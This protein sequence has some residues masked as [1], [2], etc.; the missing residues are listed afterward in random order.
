MGRIAL[1]ALGLAALFLVVVS[2]P[3][4]KRYVRITRM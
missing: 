3:D 1:V 4:I 2:A